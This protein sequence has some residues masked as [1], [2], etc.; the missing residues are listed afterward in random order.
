VIA[1]DVGGTREISDESDLV[2]VR[3]KEVEELVKTI[4][5]VLPRMKELQGLSTESVRKK[6]SWER[7]VGK[8]VKVY[9]TLLKR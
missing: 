7:N 2:L 3:A 5:N 8:Y 9:V 6:F 1:T 4:E